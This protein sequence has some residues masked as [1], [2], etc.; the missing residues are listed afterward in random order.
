[1]FDSRCT[2][3]VTEAGRTRTGS[4]AAGQ[5]AGQVRAAVL[6]LALDVSGPD[7]P[8]LVQVGTEQGRLY[9]GF[10]GTGAPDPAATATACDFL[11]GELLGDPAHA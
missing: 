6:E 7:V 10:D 8:L 9:P 2:W 11:L 4:A 1:M 3:T 5:V